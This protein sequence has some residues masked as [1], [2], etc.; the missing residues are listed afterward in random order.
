MT[1]F[2]MRQGSISRVCREGF[3]NQDSCPGISYVVQLP[4]GQLRVCA[5]T[6]SLLPELLP[7][8]W[9]EALMI[10]SNSSD[11]QWG[12]LSATSSSC[13]ITNNSKQSLHL[14]HLNSY[15]GICMTFSRLFND[16]MRCSNLSKPGFK[17]AM[18]AR[19][20]LIWSLIPAFQ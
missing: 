4:L 11:P 13:F 1:W 16:V 12:H 8:L 3:W 5:L 7:M 15:N 14:R 18:H 6:P 2:I 9:Q 20:F 10:L 17:T 19:S